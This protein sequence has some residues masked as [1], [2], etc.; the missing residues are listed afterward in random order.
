MTLLIFN[1]RYFLLPRAEIGHLRFIL[2]SYDG[3]A[4]ART[5]NQQEAV[6]EIAYPPSRSADTE[7]LLK[8]LVVELGM[9]EVP[10]PEQIPP[11]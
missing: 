5:L 11:L 4:F 1:K 3:L 8:A 2:E 9:Q 7:T 10:A 6:V